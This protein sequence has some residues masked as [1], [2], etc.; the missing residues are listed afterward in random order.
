MFGHFPS[1]LVPLSHRDII[2]IQ[3]VRKCFYRAC[4]FLVMTAFNIAIFSEIRFLTAL[5][6]L[7]LRSKSWYRSLAVF[8][9]LPFGLDDLMFAHLK[10]VH[11][12]MIITLLDRPQLLN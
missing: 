11:D 7:L 9:S 2:G 12:P 3:L 8:I 5:T 4:E 6:R 1:L 10:N